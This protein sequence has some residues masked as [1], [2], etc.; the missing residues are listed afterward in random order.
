MGLTNTRKRFQKR[1]TFERK[2]ITLANSIP[3]L[4][5][6]LY[7]LSRPAIE[8]WELTNNNCLKDGIVPIIM[9]LSK[10]LM[11]FSDSSKNAFDMDKRISS[12]ELQKRINKFNEFI[13]NIA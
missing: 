7:G 3:D 1:I 6:P 2:I 4:L 13:E 8:R 9:G 10:D 12:I 11:S 5:E